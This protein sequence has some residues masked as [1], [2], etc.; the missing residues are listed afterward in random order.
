MPS[1]VYDVPDMPEGDDHHGF[2]GLVNK[3]RGLLG[4]HEVTVDRNSKQLTVHLNNDD[5]LPHID[6]AV[7]EFGQM[8]SFTG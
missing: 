6:Q 4:V 3:I 7:Q 8:R 2:N 5:P 1:K